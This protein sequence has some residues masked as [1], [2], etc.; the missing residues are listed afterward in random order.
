M[1]AKI[2]EIQP[3]QLNNV[4]NASNYGSTLGTGIGKVTPVSNIGTLRDKNA[5]TKMEEPRSLPVGELDLRHDEIN[6]KLNVLNIQSK[7]KTDVVGIPYNEVPQG[8]DHLLLD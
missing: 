2:G 1:K 4:G 7:Y 5:S 6:P 8:P 3:P